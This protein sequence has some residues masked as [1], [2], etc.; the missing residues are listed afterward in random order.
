MRPEKLNPRPMLP[1]LSFA[2]ERRS[3]RRAAGASSAVTGSLPPGLVG[4]RPG[5][6]Y[7]SGGRSEDG[8][9]ATFRSPPCCLWSGAAPVKGGYL[10]LAAVLALCGCREDLTSPADCPA[11]CPAGSP[12][13]SDEVITPII[14]ADSSFS[15]YVQAHSAAALLVSNGLRGYEER[16]IVRFPPRSDSISVRDTLRGYTIDSVALEFS[17]IA[18]D[19][20]RSSV[21][22][23]LFRMPPSI[24][25]VTTYADVDV[26]FVPA[27]LVV[28]VP[29]PDDLNT[30]LVRTVLRGED[31]TRLAIQTEHNGVLALGVRL[32]APDVTGLRLGA[33]N[34][35]SGAV[36]DTY[37]TLDI[38][39]TGTA[40]LRSIRLPATFNSTLS[41]VP[42][43]EDPTWLTVGGIPAS[44]TLLRFDLPPR[45]RD[46][47]AVVR[48]TL[49][50]T[51]VTPVVG[52]PTDP[53]RV[54]ARAVLADIG[55]KSPVESRLV[56]QDTLSAGTSGTVAIELAGVIQ[57]LWLG[58]ST[59]PTAL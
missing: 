37:A 23:R 39:D 7:R 53:A 35:A 32:D 5:P 51:P 48:A 59:R 34:G 9:L 22:L 18:R 40:R 20:N 45:I 14:N 2:L 57:Q 44:R 10:A 21:Q 41:P 54:W 13:I 31:L 8:A 33:I 50:L 49:E 56:A 58:S 11:R 27:N 36:F 43:V 30:G 6:S 1:T 19:T 25:S 29:V 16:A 15:G 17:I 28:S 47:T 3:R 24:D 12:Y 55:A 38:A 26:A 52:L 46:S 4:I 42:D